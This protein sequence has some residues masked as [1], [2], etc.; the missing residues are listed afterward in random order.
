LAYSEHIENCGVLLEVN[1]LFR[2]LHIACGR[3]ILPGLCTQL[4]GDL[5]ASSLPGYTAKVAYCIAPTLLQAEMKCI[6]DITQFNA[7]YGRPA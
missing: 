4:L 3:P 2:N 7:H 1:N 5:G 6:V